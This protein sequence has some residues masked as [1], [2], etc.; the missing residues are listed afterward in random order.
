MI[1]DATSVAGK[2]MSSLQAPNFPSDF[3]FSETVSE[4]L[5]VS[6]TNDST[7]RFDCFTKDGP[8]DC[9]WSQGYEDS[10]ASDTYTT[11]AVRSLSASPALKL[12][13]SLLIATYYV[14]QATAGKKS[15][16]GNYMEMVIVEGASSLIASAAIML[17]ALAF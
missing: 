15:G 3:G 11:S 5:N 4:T 2:S 17:S 14:D 13:D 10:F 12:G 9:P 16:E 7:K 8:Y 6:S 1:T